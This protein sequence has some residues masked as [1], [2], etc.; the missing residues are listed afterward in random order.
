MTPASK[1]DV[2]AAIVRVAAA[3]SKDGIAK[4]GKNADQGYKFR[5]I[6]DVYNS[7][8]AII[9][10]ADLCILPR[11]KERT[12]VERPTKAG[13]ILFSVTVL[14]EYDFVSARDGS[15]H[16]ISMYGEAMDSGDKATN[17]AMSAAYKYACMEVFCIPTE[18]MPDADQQTHEPASAAKV[19]SQNVANV[20]IAQ[21]KAGI[22]YAQTGQPEPPVL[23]KQLS[24]SLE[25]EKKR[26][27]QMLAAFSELK[28]EFDKIG[29]KQQYY[30]YLGS[31][32]YEHANEIRPLSKARKMYQ[33]LGVL[34]S[35][36]REG[37][38][39]NDTDADAVLEAINL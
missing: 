2:Y 26:F 19:A 7:L 18:G 38:G 39:V 14:A 16:T 35:E 9:A 34:L 17:K 10:G 23:E 24:D 33:E 13:G 1:P 22:P 8:S 21:M 5:G 28:L 12:V 4:L 6:D 20:K 36:L 27:K 32:G 15:S 29:H 3:I 11:M 30:N 31:H 37:L 25:V